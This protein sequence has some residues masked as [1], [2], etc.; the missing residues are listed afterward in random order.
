VGIHTI[1]KWDEFHAEAKSDSR[2]D[3][4]SDM[5]LPS[6][7]SCEGCWEKPAATLCVAL[8][9]GPVSDISPPH[10]ADK[11]MELKVKAPPHPSTFMSL[12]SPKKRFIERSFP[13]P[14]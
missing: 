4:V 13:S 9:D 8:A 11:S 3:N 2:G 6:H 10:D 14:P 7:P 5:D 12:P 1:S